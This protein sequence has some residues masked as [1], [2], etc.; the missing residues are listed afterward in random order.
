VIRGNLW[1]PLDAQ[2]NWGR[3][4]TLPIRTLYRAVVYAYDFQSY[5]LL[6]LV[7]VLV[8]LIAV[9]AGVRLI[10]ASYTVFAAASLAMPLADP[11]MMRPLMSV[12]R[13][14]VVLFPAFWVLAVAA[15]RRWIPHAA[16][17]GFFA[18]GFV[19]TGA[20]YV[21]SYAIF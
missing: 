4:W 3:E 1:A 14:A 7:I 19:L 21:T 18:G 16:V 15:Q 11:F 12:P 17:V 13:F 9:L 2:K 20:L 8:P 5:W 6:D 10:P